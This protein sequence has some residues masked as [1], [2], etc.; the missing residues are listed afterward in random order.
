MDTWDLIVAGLSSLALHSF[1]EDQYGVVQKDLPIMLNSLLAFYEVTND[2]SKSVWTICI[3]IEFSC[4]TW[5]GIFGLST[6]LVKGHQLSSSSVKDCSR[7]LMTKLICNTC[8]TLATILALVFYIL[9]CQTL[10]ILACSS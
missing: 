7:L 9:F 8:L 3:M 5:K 4:R 2:H 1:E 10:W 6:F